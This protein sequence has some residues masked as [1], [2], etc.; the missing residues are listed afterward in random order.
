LR[1]EVTTPWW[2]THNQM[3]TL[4]PGVQSLSFPGAPA[5]WLFPGDP[6]VPSTLGPTRYGNFGPRIGIAYSP[7]GDDGSLWGKLVGNGRTSIRAAYGIYYTSFEAAA[8]RQEQGDAPYGYYWYGGQPEFATPFILRESGIN[9]GQRFPTPL[10]PLNVSPKNPDTS[11]NWSQ[12]EPIESSPGFY[13]GNHVPY[14]EDYNFSLQRQFGNATML[15]VS[16]VGSEGH[17]LFS[18]IEA[19]PAN[20][21]LC[22]SLSQA[23]EVSQ[24]PGQN[25]T[26]G[27]FSETA[28]GTGY[29]YP[30]AGGQTLAR[31]LF[32]PAFGG[33][34]WESTE[35]NSVYNS[36]QVSFRHQTGRSEFMVGYTY[37]KSID[38]S[39]GDG[40]GQGD[41]LNPI[42]TKITRALSAFNVGQNFVASY[43][44]ELPFQKLWRANRLTEGWQVSGITRFATGFPVYMYENDDHALI[45]AYQSGQGNNVD[46][47]NYTPGSLDK[48]NPRTGNPYFNT[49]LFSM[50]AL[51]QLGT[52]N[53]RFFSGPGWNNFDLALSKEVKLTESMKVE[54][55]GE[56]FN[57]FNHAQFQSPQGT[58]NNGT[59]GYVTGANA[60]RIGQVSARFTF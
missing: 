9:Q 8:N 30:A 39:S 54:V 51:G 49:S 12:F 43:S 7:H 28:P 15:M 41:N 4:L 16:Y 13:P 60:P 14:G 34:G 3:E 38:N 11:I 6:G 55:R 48:Q 46:T 56:F 22:L 37:S 53:R 52:A 17:K 35:A 20:P 44:Y 36:L 40:L 31:P 2:E 10:P 18:T 24:V 29:F 58:I 50:E 23:S 27:P 19:N 47:P 59:F 33:N 57:A 25:S 5:G 32:G 42:D 1:W 45:G 21:A 26:C